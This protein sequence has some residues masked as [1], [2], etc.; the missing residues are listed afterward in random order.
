MLIAITVF[1]EAVTTTMPVVASTAATPTIQEQ[2]VPQPLPNPQWPEVDQI[3]QNALS[4]EVPSVAVGDSVDSGNA[5]RSSAQISA[6]V[7]SLPAAD[8]VIVI[9]SANARAKN[10]STGKFTVQ[11]L[12]PGFGDKSMAQ[13]EFINVAANDN[14]DES[15]SSISPLN[16]AFKLNVDRAVSTAVMQSVAGNSSLK[17]GVDYSQIDI[18]FGG[19]YLERMALYEGYGCT[20]DEVG[21]VK[22]C[23][24]MTPLRG[25]LD[26]DRK[27]VVAVLTGDILQ[28]WT[29]SS[30]QT[31]SS[32]AASLNAAWK[33]NLF[34]P[35][36]INNATVS[37]GE[38]NKEPGREG[39]PIII[40]SA[41]SSSPNG[42]WE[43]TPLGGMMDYQVG[44]QSGAASTSYP[45]PVPAPMAGLAPQIALS[46]DSGSVMV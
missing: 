13:V 4:L 5:A 38:E 2:S 9:P 1:V 40:M 6:K 34:F 42:N 22:T 12:K 27:Q 8:A 37:S 15:G 17:L 33:T 10:L 36:M 32:S 23:A 31:L 25:Y 29:E 3:V 41:G 20:F 14:P 30:G 45:I 39:P 43:A 26:P 44:L 18:P 16:V 7:E 46:Y 11:S 19:D 24:S 35:F 21:T 28:R